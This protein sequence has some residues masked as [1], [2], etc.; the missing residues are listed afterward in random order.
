MTKTET[1]REIRRDDDELVGLIRCEGGLWRPVTLFGGSLAEPTDAAEAEA[2]VRDRGLSSLADRWLATIEGDSVDVWLLEVRPDRV[3]LRRHDPM[4]TQ[5]GP[6]EWHEVA[7]L[8][9]HLA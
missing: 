5:S 4:A 8:D 3:R 7:G 2:V 9:L 1:T 6:G